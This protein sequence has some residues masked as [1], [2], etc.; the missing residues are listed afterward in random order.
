MPNVGLGTR[1]TYHVSIKTYWNMHA[2]LV[3]CFLFTNSPVIWSR[4]ACTVWGLVLKQKP[5]PWDISGVDFILLSLTREYKTCPS[6][7]FYVTDTHQVQLPNIVHTGLTFTYIHAYCC[8]TE[9]HCPSY[10]LACMYICISVLGMHFTCA[11]EVSVLHF[12][13]IHM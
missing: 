4:L 11:N 9:L 13:S 1:L 5:Q 2:T 6:S 3:S 12:H 8:N 7:K 10:I